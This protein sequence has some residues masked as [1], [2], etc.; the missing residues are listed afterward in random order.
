MIVC[1]TCGNELDNP[2][3]E[4]FDKWLHEHVHDEVS[5]DD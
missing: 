5:D 2:T 3:F 4:E 1:G